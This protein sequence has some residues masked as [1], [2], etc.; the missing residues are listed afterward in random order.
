M[1]AVVKS[2]KPE[3]V[4]LFECPMA[5]EARERDGHIGAWRQAAIAAVNAY[6][7]QLQREPECGTITLT[8]TVE[9]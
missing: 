8:L 3:R 6:F 2:V 9:K 7:S 4:L 5:R 1:K